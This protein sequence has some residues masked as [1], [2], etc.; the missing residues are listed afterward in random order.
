MF[1]LVLH[2]LARI[3]HFINRAICI[4]ALEM[5]GII[6]VGV[7]N[8]ESIANLTNKI[9]Y[10][11]KIVCNDSDLI[12]ID[13][14]VIPGVGSFDTFIGALHKSGLFDKLKEFII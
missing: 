13:K 7:G 9:G 3:D 6:D 14:L 11:S 5:I 8:V 12:D 10:Q 2:L 4:E 1:L